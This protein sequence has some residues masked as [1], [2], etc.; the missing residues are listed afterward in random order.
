MIVHSYFLLLTSF[1]SIVGCRLLY[2][3]RDHFWAPG[4]SQRVKGKEG[5]W[6]FWEIWKHLIHNW[7]KTVNIRSFFV[8]LKRQMRAQR[9][10]LGDTIWE[11]TKS[12]PVEATIII[13]IYYLHQ[14]L[15]S[16]TSM[17]KYVLWSLIITK[18]VP[19][20]AIIMIQI[21]YLYQILY[22]FMVHISKLCI[23]STIKNYIH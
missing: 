16:I 1:I 5:N 8:Q 4:G 6:T 15:F 20:E 21:Y 7:T 14:I 17:W 23:F 18:S 10:D 22:T 3:W 9:E 13:W 12:I 19:V 11:I 2:P